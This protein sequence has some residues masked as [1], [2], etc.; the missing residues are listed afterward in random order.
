MHL[1][2]SSVYSDA[3]CTGLHMLCNSA[4]PPASA[5]LHM[6]P[7]LVCLF[8]C[9]F[10]LCHGMTSLLSF[11]IFVCPPPHLCH[12]LT[13]SNLVRLPSAA[14]TPTPRCTCATMLHLHSD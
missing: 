5:P 10:P 9:L 12:L 8:V 3:L 11:L 1:C 6:P 7:P 13:P 14:S 4:L 2:S